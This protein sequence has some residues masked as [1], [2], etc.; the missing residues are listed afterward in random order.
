MEVHLRFI[1]L[2]MR[3]SRADPLDVPR[4]HRPIS[5]ELFSTFSIFCEIPGLAV[6]ECVYQTQ[7]FDRA[8]VLSD[9]PSQ[10]RRGF[11]A[12]TITTCTL[13]FLHHWSFQG[14]HFHLL[15]VVSHLE[16]H[17]PGRFL[18]SMT[19]VDQQE[20]TTLVPGGFL[21]NRSYM[22]GL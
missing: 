4:E 7:P 12:V 9:G 14:L 13:R 20:Q 6:S 8:D 2:S 5:S 17:K 18:F 11:A 3:G 22:E 10:R 21:K 16:P 15:V 19:R 1:S